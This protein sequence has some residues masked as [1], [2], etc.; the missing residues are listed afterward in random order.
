MSQFE[1]EN[2]LGRGSGKVDEETLRRA[3]READRRRSTANVEREPTA[4]AS[5]RI[6]EEERNDR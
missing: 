3:W 2:D 6:S 5:E 4:R 1:Q